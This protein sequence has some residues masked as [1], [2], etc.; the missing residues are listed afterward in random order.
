MLDVQSTTMVFGGLIAVNK[1]S[2]KV[3]QDE[4]IGLIGPNGAGKTTLFNCITGIY[5]PTS[6]D[7]TLSRGDTTYNIVKT[8]SY[9]IIRKGMAR[10]FQNVRLFQEMTVL[11]NVLVG[12]HSQ[13][14]S[15]FFQTVFTTNAFIKEEKEAVDRAYRLLDHFDLVSLANTPVNALPF[16]RQKVL[17]IARALMSSPKILLLD[18][19]AAGLNSNETDML[20]NIIRNVKKEFGLS[21]LL[22]EHDM[23]FVM[24]LCKRIYVMDHGECIAE[25]TPE[26][27]RNNQHV[28]NAYLGAP[29]DE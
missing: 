16:G 25:G 26:E 14:K 29:E 11:E 22:I 4:I 6:G 15:S 19:P 28:I 27:I 8:K 9:H 17:E 23:S 20:M 5:K 7:I 2:L 13:L 18:E 21:I 12:L 10:T 3:D 24:S 1:V